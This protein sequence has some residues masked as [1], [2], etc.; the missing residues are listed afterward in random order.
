MEKFELW[1]NQINNFEEKNFRN[2][3]C[4]IGKENDD[5]EILLK[6]T[7][8]KNLILKVKYIMLDI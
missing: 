7:Y 6:S 8:I 4:F 1:L 2:R 3:K 5:L